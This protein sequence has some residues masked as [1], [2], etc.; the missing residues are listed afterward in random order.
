MKLLIRLSSLETKVSSV[1]NSSESLNTITTSTSDSNIKLQEE[2]EI[3]KSKTKNSTLLIVKEKICDCLAQ[4][5]LLKDTRN[6]RASS[7]SMERLSLLEYSLREVN[8]LLNAQGYFI[9][10][11]EADVID[12]SVN[13]VV[14]QLESL[15]RNKLVDMAEKK[16]SLKENGKLNVNAELC[17]L[18][19]KVAYENILVGR[20]QESLSAPPNTGEIECDRLL[21]KEILDTS[22]LI[23]SLQTK[24]TNN[25][26]KQLP[27]S[28]T[29]V[30]YLTKI[31]AKCLM[32]AARGFA[33]HKKTLRRF[34]FGPMLD[35]LRDKQIQLNAALN[36]YKS[37]KL[38]QLADALA[39]E[40]VSLASDTTCRLKGLDRS[41]IN[42]AWATAQESVNS[43]LIQSEINHILMRAAQVYTFCT[44]THLNLIYIYFFK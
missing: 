30:E 6:K 44:K 29:S 21:N 17:I 20:I 41:T 14:K 23:A 1:A 11:T 5:S 26:P 4:I 15:L 33:I 16:R 25:A 31:L 36:T 3:D 22:H 40:T 39:S 43:E 13:S 28:K 7:P 35:S 24:L 12:N 10:S 2:Q 42:D 18:A 37:T 8:D 19:E 38:P 9:T 34:R 27:T 32:K